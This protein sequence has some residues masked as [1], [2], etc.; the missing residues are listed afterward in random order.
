MQE[1]RSAETT[2]TPGMKGKVFETAGQ[3]ITRD[4]VEISV[5]IRLFT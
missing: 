1:E 3:N 2:T 5:K 4:E